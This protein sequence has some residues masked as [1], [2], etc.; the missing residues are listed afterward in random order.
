MISLHQLGHVFINKHFT[1][2]KN[3]SN[4]SDPVI[5]PIYVQPYIIKTMISS[6]SNNL[7]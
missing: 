5:S 7:F 4:Q 1:S 3:Q 2:L 6:R